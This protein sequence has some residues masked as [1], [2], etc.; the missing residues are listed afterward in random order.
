[1]PDTKPAITQ[2]NALAEQV[3]Q[4]I[5]DDIFNFVLLPGDR[6]TETEMA[7]RYGA[8]RTPIRDALYRLE[9]EDYLQVAFRSG[10]S[11]RPFD[12]KRFDQLY[13]L[14]IVLE[15]AA[16]ARLCEAQTPTGL[17]ALEAVWSTPASGRSSDGKH[18]CELDEDF[19]QGLVLASGNVEMARVHHEVT[20]KIRVVR[21]LDFTFQTRIDATYDEHHEILRLI[22]RRQGAQAASRLRTHIEASKAE[23][24]KITLH[25]LYEARE[26]ADKTEAQVAAQ[27][28]G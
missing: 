2:A 4:R 26:P 5:K 9:R 24:R 1:M 11:V 15:L 6:F 13:D 28:A 14:R 17:D 25:M 20:E 3:Y 27:V 8:S 19:H 7:R 18:V 10:W 16:V 21:R 12:F 23:V 22:S